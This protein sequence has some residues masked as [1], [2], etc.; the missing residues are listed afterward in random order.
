MLRVR[1][2]LNSPHTMQAHRK[3]ILNGLAVLPCEARTYTHAS[4]SPSIPMYPL[5]SPHAPHPQQIT[6]LS[7]TF[8]SVLKLFFSSKSAHF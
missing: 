4:P 3:Q 7:N 1:N 2:G 5:V 8:S 6:M